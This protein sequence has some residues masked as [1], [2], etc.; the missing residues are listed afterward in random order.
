MRRSTVDA[1][2]CLFDPSGEESRTQLFERT[3]HVFHGFVSDAVV[4]SRYGVG[5]FGGRAPERGLRHNGDKLLL[6]TCARAIEGEYARG[7]ETFSDRLDD[8]E[9]INTL[10]SAHAS[11]RCVIVDSSFDWSDDAAP[12]V[13]LNETG[14]CEV[15]V[16]G[17]T[18][19]DMW[20]TALSVVTVSAGHAFGVG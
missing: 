12:R 16:K 9:K 5:V 17:F 7:R 10:D 8:P 20:R 3:G 13:P 14:V 15:H 4:G 18:Q 2:A 6:D 11:T 1:P 19:Q